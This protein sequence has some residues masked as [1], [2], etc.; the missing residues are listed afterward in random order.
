M[1]EFDSD[2]VMAPHVSGTKL[3]RPPPGLDKTLGWSNALSGE[4]R[5]EPRECSGRSW[6]VKLDIQIGFVADAMTVIDQSDH[7]VRPSTRLGRGI[8]CPE[9]SSRAGIGDSTSS[10]EF[11]P[12]VVLLLGLLFESAPGLAQWNG[13]FHSSQWHP[14]LRHCTVSAPHLAFKPRIQVSICKR[15]ITP[16]SLTPSPVLSSAAMMG[17]NVPRSTIPGNRKSEIGPASAAASAGEIV[18]SH[19]LMESYILPLQPTLPSPAD[20][21][22]PEAGPPTASSLFPVQVDSICKASRMLHR[23]CCQFPFQL[24]MHTRYYWNPIVEDPYV[25]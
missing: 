22:R 10:I 13:S 4:S 14:V 15:L 24:R 12:R 7:T 5:L 25:E 8:P 1:S 21:V 6:T 11:F 19:S 20:P 18:P 2:D 9:L 16:N 17:S 23:L 3:N